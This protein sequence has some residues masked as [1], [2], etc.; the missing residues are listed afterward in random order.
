MDE[1]HYHQMRLDKSDPDGAEEWYCPTCGRRLLLHWPPEYKRAILEPGDTHAIRSGS[2]GSGDVDKGQGVSTG[3]TA[4][5]LSQWEEW[6]ADI[7]M[8]DL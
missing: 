2:K 6:L 3:A 7:D 8:S 5:S 4:P 1:P